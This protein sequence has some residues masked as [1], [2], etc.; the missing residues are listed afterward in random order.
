MNK[1]KLKE[2]LLKNCENQR[3]NRYIGSNKYIKTFYY[4][5]DKELNIINSRASAI[6]LRDIVS[7]GKERAIK[8]GKKIVNR[9]RVSKYYLEA[10]WYLEAEGY[11]GY[12]MHG[13]FL[14]DNE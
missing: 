6:W 13:S 2:W 7:I 14:M 10:E 5:C 11:I 1:L 4:Y 9:E 12:L 3:I 8:I